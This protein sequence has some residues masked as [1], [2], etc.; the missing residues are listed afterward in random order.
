VAECSTYS[1][2]GDGWAFSVWA[3]NTYNGPNLNTNGAKSTFG[4]YEISINGA[5]YKIGKA[6]M[7]RVTQSSG[8]PTRLHQQL[9]KLGEFFGTENVSHTLTSLGE[10]TTQ[11]AKLAETAR[12]QMVF[13]QTGFVLIGNW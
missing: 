6:D 13:E 9:R 3:H 12:L 2:G 7:G 5:L 1:V 8:L 10:V 11:N 4:I